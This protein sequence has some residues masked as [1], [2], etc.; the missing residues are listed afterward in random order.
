MFVVCVF[1]R[2][3][4]FLLGYPICWH[5]IIYR[6]LMILCISVFSPLSLIILFIWIFCLFLFS[7]LVNTLSILFI[8]SKTQL[9]MSLI[10]SLSLFYYLFHLFLVR[11]FLCTAFANFGLLAVEALYWNCIVFWFSHYN[12]QFNV[13]IWFFF[14]FSVSLNFLFCF[15]IVFLISLIIYPGSL[16]ALWASLGQLLWILCQEIHMFPF[17]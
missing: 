4:P 10:F 6:S 7:S 8:F 17:L 5:I 15:Y 2:I 12:F 14:T 9:W 13:S 11:S 3:Y 1:L 16:V